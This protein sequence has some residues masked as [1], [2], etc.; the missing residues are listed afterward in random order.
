MVPVLSA[1]IT[2]VLPNVSTTAL[3][4][5]MIPSRISFQA[6]N[7]INVVKA[8]GIS[9][10]KIDIAKVKPT[11]RLSIIR[12]EEHTS[13]LQSRENLVCRLLLEKKKK[14]S[15]YFKY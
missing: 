13:E 8:T 2:V 14:K 3:R 9:S 15:Q 7:A 12:S 6:P 5:I 10:G 11:K 4:L 1:Q